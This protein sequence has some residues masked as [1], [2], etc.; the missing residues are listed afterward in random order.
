[1]LWMKCAM[2]K[3]KNYNYAASILTEDAVQYGPTWDKMNKKNFWTST[4]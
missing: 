3:V 2:M 4:G 1:M